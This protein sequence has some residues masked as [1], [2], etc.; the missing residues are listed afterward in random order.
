MF[1]V[2][3]I[4]VIAHYGRTVLSWPGH[5]VL[6]PERRV[7]LCQ[8]QTFLI[9]IDIQRYIGVSVGNFP[10]DVGALKLAKFSRIDSPER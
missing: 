5:A 10:V 3:G 9:R 1:K 7:C 6:M 2:S 4:A 8:T